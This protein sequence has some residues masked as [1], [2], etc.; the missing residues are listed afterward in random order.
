MFI[1]SKQAIIKRSLTRIVGPQNRTKWNYSRIKL[2]P[3]KA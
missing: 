1:Y 2:D 3:T